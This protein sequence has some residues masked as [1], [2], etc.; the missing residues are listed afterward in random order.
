M[1]IAKSFGFAEADAVN[2]ARMI[3][4]VADHGVAFIEQHLEQPSV[5]IEAGTVEDRIVSPEKRA[6]RAL[7][8]FVNVLRPANEPHRCHAVAVIAQTLYGRLDDSRM[9]G[10]PEV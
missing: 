7:E 10:Q 2:H 3:Q 6:N 9:I 4:G 8:F 5:R 1:S